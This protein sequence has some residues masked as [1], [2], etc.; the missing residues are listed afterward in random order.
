MNS[1]RSLPA[2]TIL[3]VED[4]ADMRGLMEIALDGYG[5]HLIQ[6]ASA[7]EALECWREH[8]GDIDLLVTDLNLGQGGSGLDLAERLA[9]LKPSLKVLAISGS[10]DGSDLTVSGRRIELLKKPFVLRDV[11]QHIERALERRIEIGSSSGWIA[12]N[13]LNQDGQT[14]GPGLAR[15]PASCLDPGLNPARATATG[16]S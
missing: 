11:P 2:A 13:T 7:D 10:C 14:V 15:N 16:W 9:A 6:A 8:D 12:Q 4:S 3:L 1:N 5:Y